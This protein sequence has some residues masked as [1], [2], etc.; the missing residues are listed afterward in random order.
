MPETLDE[1]LAILY[2]M[3][4]LNGLDG[5]KEMEKWKLKAKEL[6]VLKDEG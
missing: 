6:L 3:A 1:K 4:W 5:D 2:R